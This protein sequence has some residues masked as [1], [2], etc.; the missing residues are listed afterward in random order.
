MDLEQYGGLEVGQEDEQITPGK[1]V[2]QYLEE[3]E[4]QIGE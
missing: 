3:T 1:Y 2:M 4:N